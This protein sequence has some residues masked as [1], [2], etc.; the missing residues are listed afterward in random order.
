MILASSLPGPKNLPRPQAPSQPLSA[1]AENQANAPVSSAEG[2]AVNPAPNPLPDLP[3]PLPAE[4]ANQSPSAPTAASGNPLVNSP[5]NFHGANPPL[6]NP[7]KPP[8]RLQSLGAIIASAIG[9]APTSPPDSQDIKPSPGPTPTQSYSISI[10]PTASA[11]VINGVTSIL[12]AYGAEGGVVAGILPIAVG[13]QQISRNAASQYLVAGQ[14]ITPGAPPINVQGT[15]VS[16]A[17]SASAIVIAGSTI[18]ISSTSVPGF[19]VGAET[20]T[21]NSASQYIAGG[22]TL[23]PGGLALT[24]SGT[25]ISLAPSGTQVVV[26]S[27][28]IGLAPTFS[29]LILPP[30]LT[31]GSQTYTA[32][33]DSEYTIGSQILTPGGPA[34]TVSGTRL[35]L[36][37]SATQVVVGSS[38]I[39]LGP[40]FTPPPI[41]FGS[42]TF[43]ANSASDY[44]I[45]RQTLIPGA[46]AITVSGTPISLA[47]DATQEVIGSSTIELAPATMPPLL[48]FG[49]QTF[50]ANTASDY[51]IDGQTLVPGAPPITISNT[52]ISLAPGASEV[53]IGGSTEILR[54]GLTLPP[55][56]IGSHTFTANNAGAYVIGSQTLTPGASGIVVP[57]SVLSPGASLSVF[58]VAGQVFTANPTAFS[59]DGTTISAGG[60]GVTIFGTPVSLQASGVLDI[61][62]STITLSSAKSTNG[63]GLAAFTGE[64]DRTALQLLYSVSALV[65]ILSV[66]AML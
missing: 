14:T 15:E 23:V 66:A 64:G 2:H 40:V 39:G 16:L 59:I 41:T 53:V 33:S 55:I 47:P 65:L 58:T 3:R 56:I 32:S 34:I 10:A 17:P 8:S 57:E 35:S 11:I 5:E 26:G 30:P 7:A 31:L 27:S 49:S 42:Q 43:T 61:G 21:A 9:I 46:P 63:F 52:P 4:T 54:S 20:V 1:Q 37:P 60:P 24:V 29:P 18:A 44:I 36:A 45:D 22:H 50:T 48:T 38:T 28:T 62:N 51:I 19:T 6:K 12:P 13:S 25:R